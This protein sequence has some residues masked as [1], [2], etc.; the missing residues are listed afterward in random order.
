MDYEVP[1]D[2]MKRVL[3]AARDVERMMKNPRP[4]RR[5]WHW[6]GTRGGPDRVSGLAT[7]AVTGGSF[8]IYNVKPISGSSP[9]DDP[10]STSETLAVSNPF[11]FDLDD[12][13]YVHAEWNR[14]TETWQ[15]YQGACPS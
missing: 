2:D 6:Q 12:D 13:G 8:T 10:D 7:A 4:Q 1:R 11:T 15:A 9:L 3:Q 5:R 14:T